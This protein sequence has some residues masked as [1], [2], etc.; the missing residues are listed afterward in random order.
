M[1]D[2]ACLAR[3][4]GARIIGGCCGTTPE[5]LRAMALAL[6]SRPAGPT[7]ERATIEALLGPLPVPPVADP[8]AGR[9]RRARRRRA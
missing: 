2:Y 9:E 1:A 3:D 8:E 5:H 7:P 4:A 6:A